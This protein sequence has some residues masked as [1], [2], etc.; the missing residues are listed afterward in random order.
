MFRSIH[1]E[2]RHIRLGIRRIQRDVETERMALNK[3]GVPKLHVADTVSYVSPATAG[4]W[5][6]GSLW[7]QGVDVWVQ[8]AC[9]QAAIRDWIGD[10]NGQVEEVVDVR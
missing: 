6:T 9:F 1:R 5:E 8:P 10:G 2:A 7:R 4:E 3:G